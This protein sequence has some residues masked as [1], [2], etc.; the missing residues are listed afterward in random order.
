MKLILSTCWADYFLLEMDFLTHSYSK[1]RERLWLILLVF[2][3]MCIPEP[4]TRVKKTH[5]GH[6][7]QPVTSGESVLPEGKRGENVYAEL[8]K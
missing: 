2:H 7:P 8:T 5:L 3:H 1:P 4:I 6:M